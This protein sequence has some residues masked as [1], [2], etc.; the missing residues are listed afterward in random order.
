MR[1]KLALGQKVRFNKRCVLA[2]TV[3]KNSGGYSFAVLIAKEGDAYTGAGVI[4]K[5]TETVVV[6]YASHGTA[7]ADVPVVNVAGR[8]A[9]CHQAHLD[10]I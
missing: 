9:R 5:G 3:P 6:D 2:P 4:E 1:T 10:P 7:T 8:L